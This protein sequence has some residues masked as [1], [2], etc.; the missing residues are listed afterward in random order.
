[1]KRICITFKEDHIYYDVA[2]FYCD[3]NYK[4]TEED[5]R[6]IACYINDN[7]Y[8]FYDQTDTDSHAYEVYKG[9]FR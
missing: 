2:F 5:K 6:R 4:I 7:D 8:R 3:D 1:M 9:F